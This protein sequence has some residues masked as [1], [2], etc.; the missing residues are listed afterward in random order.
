M[1]GPRYDHTMTL[2]PNGKVL[3]VGGLDGTANLA[4]ASALL[5]VP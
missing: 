4:L 1:P 3:V 2:L 5:Y